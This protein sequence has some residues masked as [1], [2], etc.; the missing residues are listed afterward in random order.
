MAPEKQL[1]PEVV[2]MVCRT[3]F[4]RYKNPV[5]ILAIIDY[6]NAEKTPAPPGYDKWDVFNI[7]LVIDIGAR[8]CPDVFPEKGPQEGGTITLDID[9]EIRSIEITDCSYSVTEDEYDL[10]EMYADHAVCLAA[11][12]P[13]ATISNA[14]VD[15]GDVSPL[16]GVALSVDAW[17]PCFGDASITLAPNK[18]EPIVGGRLTISDVTQ[19]TTPSCRGGSADIR[20]SGDIEIECQNGKTFRGNFTVSTMFNW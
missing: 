14:V 2:R 1:D 8:I 11:I 4:E 13:K 16:L 9:G 12:I 7:L 19:F 20:L 15:E 10:L 3:Y 5:D 18:A 17:S 6:L